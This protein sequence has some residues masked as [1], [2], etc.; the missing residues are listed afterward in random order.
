MRL[1]TLEK[2]S[3]D[4]P[5]AIVREGGLGAMLSYLDFFNMHVQRTAMTA[6]AN[7]CRKLSTDSLPMIRNVMPIIQNVLS[8]SDQRLVESACKCVVRVVESY[9]HHPDLLETILENDL[10]DAVNALLLPASSAGATPSTSVSTSTYTDVLKALSTAARASPRVAVALLENN[11]VETLYHLLTGSP[12]PAEDGSG[13]QGPA[14]IQNSPHTRALELEK[15]GAAHRSANAAA[16]AVVPEAGGGVAVADMAVLQNLA[17]RPKEQ[18]HEAL[19]L[20]G[21]LLPPLPRDG[22][23][24]ARQYT[25]KA[26]LKKKARSEKA[27][28][29]VAK[30]AASKAD[31]SAENCCAASPTK[32]VAH[33]HS[34]E[35]NKPSSKVAA[36]ASPSSGSAKTGKGKSER[37]LAKEAAQARRIEMLHGRERLVRRFTQL[38]LPTLVEVYAASVALHVRTKAMSGILKIISFVEPEALKDVLKV[39]SGRPKF[40]LGFEDII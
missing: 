23:F 15:D 29:D 14:S 35:A 40:R 12:A 17:H 16:V 27:A 7:C 33:S 3:I 32:D 24:D 36:D 13:G 21:E 9:K 1:Q 26:S 18:V 11:V 25:E 19:S 6:A 39:S 31:P 28:R 20:V 8:Y 38:V 37:E 30:A 22:V 5:G 10:I 2:I 34:T 4:Y